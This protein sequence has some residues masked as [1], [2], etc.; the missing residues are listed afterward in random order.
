MSFFFTLAKIANISWK[1][2]ETLGTLVLPSTSL[3]PMLL[4][5]SDHNAD[6]PKAVCL[7]IKKVPHTLVYNQINCYR[8]MN[9]N[10][11]Y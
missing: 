5:G 9:A 1:L 3:L 2:K 11:F 4:K 6:Y 8:K 10:F 7:Q